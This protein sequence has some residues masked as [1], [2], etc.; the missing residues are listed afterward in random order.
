MRYEPA[1]TEFHINKLS[2]QPVGWDRW[3]IAYASVLIFLRILNSYS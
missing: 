2:F 3:R 1:K